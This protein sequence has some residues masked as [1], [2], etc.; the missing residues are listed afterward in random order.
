MLIFVISSSC[1]ADVEVDQTVEE[2]ESATPIITGFSPTSVNVTE[3]I[4]VEGEFLQ[5][6]DRAFIGDVETEI[7]SRVSDTQILLRVSLD[8]PSTGNIMLINDLARQ[9]QDNLEFTATSTDVVSV[10]FP[11]P[12]ITTTL[13][14][15]AT[16]NDVLVIEGNAVNLITAITF[17]DVEATIA[18]QSEDAIAI[19]VPNPGTLDSVEVTFSYNSSNGIITESLSPAFLVNIPTPEASATPRIMTR[20]NTVIIKGSNM[21]FTNSVTVNSIEVEITKKEESELN[22]M[23]PPEIP[24]GIAEVVIT[25]TEDRQTIFN[26]PYINGEYVEMFDMD[27]TPIDFWNLRTD[28][29]DTVTHEEV[30][31]PLEQPIFRIN[32][33][34]ETF[35]FGNS[36]YRVNY[37]QRSSSG[38]SE[39]S[40]DEVVNPEEL[41]KLANM[42]DGNN[43]NGTPVLHFFMRTNEKAS[44]RFHMGNSDRREITSNFRNTNGEWLLIAVELNNPIDNRFIIGGNP[45]DIQF[46][47]TP[48]SSSSVPEIKSGEYDWFIITDKVLTEFGAV[49]WTDTNSTTNFWNAQ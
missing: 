36:Y 34:T 13:A 10:N 17:G 8:A 3:T 12:S 24:T 47:L 43:F 49:N 25:D 38:L 26:I 44:M 33:G 46:R 20:D 39:G 18:F 41:D 45:A 29:D 37:I 16:A 14:T 28:R 2:I 4:L 48:T 19:I 42:Y 32:G 7:A 31:D 11:T 15:E 35:P 23:V 27:S 6:V 22:F 5:F 9:G 30:T 1:D 40:V 21:E